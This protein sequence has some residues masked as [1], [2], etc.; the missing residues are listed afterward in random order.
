MHDRNGSEAEVL[1]AER[2]IPLPAK[3]GHLPSV[4]ALE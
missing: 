3:D 1:K 2:L 4:D